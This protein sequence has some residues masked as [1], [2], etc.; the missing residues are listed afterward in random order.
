M[1]KREREK[2]RK[3]EAV[4]AVEKRKRENE[5]KIKRLKR[6]KKERHSDVERGEYKEKQGERNRKREIGL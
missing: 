5:R 6:E 3:M 2:Q 1:K 4:L